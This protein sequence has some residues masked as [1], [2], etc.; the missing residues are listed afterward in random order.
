MPRSA[1]ERWKRLG[2][3]LPRDTRERV[4]EPAYSD[5]VYRWLTTGASDQPKVPF[6]LQVVGTYVGCIPILIP[7]MFV[8]R[9]KLTLL[10]RTLIWG[11]VAI[12]ALILILSLIYDGYA[13]PGT[14]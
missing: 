7:R 14:V 4:F 11:A 13:L 2:R 1:P 3:L 8:R 6:G 10:T 5:L 12:V 9:G